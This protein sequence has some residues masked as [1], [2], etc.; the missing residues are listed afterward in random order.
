MPSLRRVRYP[1]S[2]W[3]EP[4]TVLRPRYGMSGTEIAS[5]ASRPLLQPERH[6]KRRA[7][8]Q[9]GAR[10]IKYKPPLSQCSLYQACA[11]LHL[12]SQSSVLLRHVRY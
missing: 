3:R 1:H 2:V 7:S 8:R 10:Q 11:L 6:R 9:Q 12:I 5:G 4:H